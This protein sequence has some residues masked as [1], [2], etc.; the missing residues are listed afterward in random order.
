MNSV[1]VTY[2]TDILFMKQERST[3]KIIID[4]CDMSSFNF[5]WVSSTEAQL[6]VG[7]LGSQ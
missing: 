1:Y 6:Y 4:K 7:N 3:K 5:L 2:T